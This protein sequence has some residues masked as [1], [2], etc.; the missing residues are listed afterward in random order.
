M[1]NPPLQRRWSRFTRELIE[2]TIPP[3]YSLLPFK[4]REEM[5]SAP[6]RIIRK[7][8]NHCR[9]LRI[10]KRKRTTNVPYFLWVI[11]TT[12]EKEW[13]MIRV[14]WRPSLFS[15]LGELITNQ[16]EETVPDS[17]FLPF[18]IPPP[19]LNGRIPWIEERKLP[20]CERRS[21]IFNILR[22]KVEEE[23]VEGRWITPTRETEDFS[24]S[25]I[26]IPGTFSPRRNEPSQRWISSL[27]PSF[28]LSL[29][30]LLTFHHWKESKEWI[31]TTFEWWSKNGTENDSILPIVVSTEKDAH[32][33]VIW[34]SRPM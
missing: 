2:K 15:T 17:P 13:G 30:T 10:N 24:P 23:E 8:W 5:R 22:R 16:N 34:F 3:H 32:D 18:L 11:S 31:D 27:S 28:S 26:L 21:S 20:F 9:N 19:L 29:S 1:I 33:E 7:S 6:F 14:G 25:S 4:M 12:L